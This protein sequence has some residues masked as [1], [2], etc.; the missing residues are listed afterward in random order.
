LV[1]SF[2]E[3]LKSFRENFE[4][5][6]YRVTQESLRKTLHV[7]PSNNSSP[8]RSPG[9]KSTSFEN[10]LDLAF[11]ALDSEDCLMYQNVITN[12]DIDDLFK[13]VEKDIENF[14]YFS[15]KTQILSQKIYGG[16]ANQKSFYNITAQGRNN[17][18]GKTENFP[19]IRSEFEL[20]MNPLDYLYFNLFMNTEFRKKID[21]GVQSFR[22]I[23]LTQNTKTCTTYCLTYCKY[24]SKF[25]R[26]IKEEYLVRAFKR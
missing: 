18:L 7:L 23:Y 9:L 8:L 6:L 21:P 22:V 4:K 10:D 25:D 24:E 20:E 3:R 12:S 11:N 2:P 26:K 17:Y 15:D 19:M 1:E 5:A 16:C 14:L 13:I